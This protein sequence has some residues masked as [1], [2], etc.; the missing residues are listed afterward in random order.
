MYYLEFPG[1][2]HKYFDDLDEEM[3]NSI[4]EAEFK[5]ALD[6]KDEL[7]STMVTVLD[8]PTPFTLNSLRITE[9]DDGYLQVGFK[10]LRELVYTEHY[11]LPVAEGE[12]RDIKRWEKPLGEK[13]YPTRLAPKNKYGN[14]TRGLIAKMASALQVAEQLAGFMANRT[15]RSARGKKHVYLHFT[16]KEAV[17]RGLVPGIY[18]KTKTKKAKLVPIML[19]S[20]DEEYPK[21]FDFFGVSQK[22]ADRE[23]PRKLARVI[24][25]LA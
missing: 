22:V 17:K 7:E 12:K 24:A 4:R 2:L 18:R 25:K 21:I 5:T 19:E 15:E 1:Y 11:L 3:V 6:I 16:L 23:F 9:E 8:N 20:A 13:F 10:D 14:I